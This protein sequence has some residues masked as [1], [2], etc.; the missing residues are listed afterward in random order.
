MKLNVWHGYI[1]GCVVTSVISHDKNLIQLNLLILAFDILI[2]MLR[3]FYEGG[4]KYGTY[5]KRKWNILLKEHLMTATQGFLAGSIFMCVVEG[6]TSIY[7]LISFL[8]LVITIISRI[9]I[10][11]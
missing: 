8:C 9:Q 7:L 5:K 6:Y 10:M 2:E 11:K 4:I 1:I 3:A